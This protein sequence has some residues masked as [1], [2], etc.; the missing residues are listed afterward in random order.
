MLLNILVPSKLVQSD[1]II[2]R[3]ELRNMFKST[4]KTPEQR[5]RFKMERFTKI[6]DGFQPLTIFGEKLSPVFL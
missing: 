2:T 3:K 6:V 5:H 1:M 4:I